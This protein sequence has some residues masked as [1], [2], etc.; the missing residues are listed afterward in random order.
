MATVHLKAGHVRPI[1]AGHPWVF[2]QGIEEVKGAPGPGDV[3]TVVDPK[4]KFLGRGYW[5]PKSAIPVRIL[6]RDQDDGLTVPEL[7]ARIEAAAAWRKALWKLPGEENTGFRLVHAEGDRL[8]GLIVDVYG[9]VA[10]V[11]FLTIGMKRREEE[12]IAHIARVAGV[13]SVIEIPSEKQQ[14]IEGFEAELRVARGPDVDNLRFLDRGLEY[15]IPLSIVQKTGFYFDQRDN[16]ARLESLTE[17]KRVLDAFCYVGGFALAAAR[18]GAREVLA[19]DRSAGAIATGSAIA[20]KNKLA[21]RITFNV[22]DLKKA[23]ADLHRKSERFDIVIVDPPKLAPT[24]RHLEKGK[25]AYRRLN[26][27]ALKLV[28][29]GGMLLSC[30]CS[31]ALKPSGLMRILGVAAADAGRDVTLLSMG[32]QSP[33]HPIP[34]AFPEGRYLKCA[35]VQVR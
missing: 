17:G 20:A 34:A 8:A 7:A 12:L 9:D 22:A 23:L 27:N 14:R 4:G 5:S 21:D 13:K 30:S 11:Q 19:I 32:E 35:F 29:P 10:A 26:A 16:R 6:T 31:A 25:K 1:W 18:G 33:D 3:V 15:E 28:K 2:K 24:A